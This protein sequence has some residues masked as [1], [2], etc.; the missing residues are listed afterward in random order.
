M[1]STLVVG[2]FYLS[3]AL[4]LDAARVGLVSSV[5]PLMVALMGTP[6]GRLADRF[7][8]QRMTLAGLLGMAAGAVALAM[9]S[10][11][12]GVPGYIVPMVVLTGGYALFQTANNTAVMR[13]VDGSRRGVVSGMLS[14]SRNLGLVTGASAMGAVFAFATGTATLDAAGPGEH[15]HR[16]VRDLCRRRSGRFRR[17]GAAGGGPRPRRGP[18]RR[19]TAQAG[20][21]L[22]RMR[23]FFQMRSLSPSVRYGCVYSDS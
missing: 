11:A 1:M 7:G 21:G 15:R 13:D 17:C 10:V 22:R 4:G 12:F 20:R 5:G 19:R 16:H 2:P 6:A 14:L 3:R 9:A 18:Q 23:M 8:A